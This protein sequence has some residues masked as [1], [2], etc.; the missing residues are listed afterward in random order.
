ME[1]ECEIEKAG[2]PN[3]PQ[4]KMWTPLTQKGRPGVPVPKSLITKT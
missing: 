1:K 2:T 4:K 3:H